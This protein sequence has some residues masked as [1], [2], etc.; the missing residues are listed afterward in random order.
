M[1]RLKT[2][3]DLLNR[4]LTVIMQNKKLLV[5][6]MIEFIS[7]III[8]IFF[9]SPALFWNSGYSITDAQHWKALG[10]HMLQIA[11]KNHADKSIV[12]IILND[13]W[14]AWSILIYLISMFTATFFSV[15]FY[16]EIINGLNNRG[17][18]I[19]RGIKAAI[20]KIKLIMIWSLFAGIVGIIIRTLEER[21]SFVGRWI[22][23]LIG[24]AWSVASIFAAPVIIKEEKSL[25][26][27][28]VLKTSA[29]MLKKTWGESIIGYLGIGGFLLAIFIV[30]LPLFIAVCIILGN[31]I[32]DMAGVIFILIF[33]YIISMSILGYLATIANHVYRGALFLYATEGVVPG[34]YDED[35]MNKAWKV[36]RMK[37]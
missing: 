13:K 7:I 5:F 33:L 19:S 11:G 22:V 3:F 35:M 25:N 29:L 10:N 31:S 20:S 4:S 1:G 12:G 28:K 6:P 23:G 27:F 8:G 24:I 2:S 37:K 36:K 26:P 9:L 21:L 34:P 30:S 16:N 32:P 15:A 14:Y 17:V 18:S